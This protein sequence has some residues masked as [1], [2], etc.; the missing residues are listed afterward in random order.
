MELAAFQ[1]LADLGCTACP[2]CSLLMAAHTA[3]PPPAPMA[4][5]SQ[6][7]H[8]E[9]CALP[10]SSG[11]VCSALM[12]RWLLPHGPLPLWLA[13]WASPRLLGLC[14]CSARLSV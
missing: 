14:P 2:P 11:S 7:L 10:T 6:L 8:G 1:R 4:A 12:A 13:G 9:G 3:V 5:V